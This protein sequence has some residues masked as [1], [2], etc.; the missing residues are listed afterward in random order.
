MGDTFE[1]VDPGKFLRYSRTYPGVL[2]VL[3][4][5]HFYYD[6]Q[7]SLRHFRLDRSRKALLA[8]DHL[9]LVAEFEMKSA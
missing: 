1:A 6:R 4:L 3:H 9:L 5:D 2:P 8:S 7:L